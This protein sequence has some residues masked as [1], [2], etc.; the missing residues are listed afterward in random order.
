[1]EPLEFSGGALFLQ[2]GRLHTLSLNPGKR[3]YGEKLVP[4]E[5]REYREWNP[6]RSKLSAYFALGGTSFPFRRDSHVLY[7]GAASGTTASHVA[8]MVP[9][10]KVFCVEFSPRSF[11]DLTVNA[12]GRSNMYPILA[13]AAN[14]GEYSFIVDHVDVVY[15]DVAQKRQADILVDNM[16]R[17][18]ATHGI[19]C[20]KARSEDVTAPPARIFDEVAGRLRE[21]GCRVEEL[22]SLEPYEKDHAMAIVR[23]PRTVYTVAMD[24][25]GFLMVYNEKRNG[26]E[27]PGGK[28]EPGETPE[29]AAERECFEES[30]YRVAVAECRDMGYCDVCACRILGKEQEGEMTP[31]MFS[32]L[33]AD[34][35]FNED[36]YAEVLSWATS[37]LKREGGLF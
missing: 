34:L 32:Q 9:D 24:E 4:S 14:P 12:E 35:A 18:G 2:K 27:M 17:Y 10:G 16:N 13:D 20:I 26:W 28:I 1:M 25:S 5:D 36:E 15:A 11:R 29:E 8:D 23:R 31:R 21:R 22:V 19:L 7:L 30:G 3:V 6:N 33:P 37:V